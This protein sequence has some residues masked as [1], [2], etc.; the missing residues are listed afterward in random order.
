MLAG[1]GSDVGKS[2]IA[3][4]FCRIFL[5]DGYSLVGYAYLITVSRYLSV[6]VACHL[7]IYSLVII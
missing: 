1:T 6:T 7:L 2:I 4:A 5:Q 3:T